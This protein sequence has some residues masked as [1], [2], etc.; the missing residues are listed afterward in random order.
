[1]LSTETLL[2]A[3]DVESAA[4]PVGGEKAAWGK[5]ETAG[6]LW[7]DGGHQSAAR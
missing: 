3:T 2:Q 7:D 1:M 6:G 5:C 4:A